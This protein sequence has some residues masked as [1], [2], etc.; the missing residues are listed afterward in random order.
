MTTT[1]FRPGHAVSGVLNAPNWG[2]G[3]SDEERETLTA[4][5]IAKFEELARERTGDQTISYCAYT[6]EI[7]YAVH[8]RTT[9]EHHCLDAITPHGDIDWSEL[10]GEA[11][12]WVMEHDSEIIQEG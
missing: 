8:G 5:L 12:E 7:L 9:A 10:A 1:S 2:D 6:S 4:A 11:G 3:L